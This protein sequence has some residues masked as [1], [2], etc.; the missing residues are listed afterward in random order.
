[1]TMFEPDIPPATSEHFLTRKERREQLRAE[2]IG[3]EAILGERPID[4]LH[5][6]VDGCTH[7]DY[8]QATIY[9]AGHITADSYRSVATAFL[10]SK[11][12]EVLDPF[13]P[14]RDFRGREDTV[15]C[16]EL[17]EGDIEDITHSHAVL[18]DL[19]IPSAGTSMECWFAHSIGRPVY[20]FVEKGGRVSPWI[21]Y[22]AKDNKT[23][24]SLADALTTLIADLG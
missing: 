10:E 19:T 2:R 4:T 15:T 8:T 3:L 16:Q 21:N 22:V 13:R 12:F 20:P 6:P 7:G 23:F 14:E 17:V 5:C 11:G 9:L 24:G 1:M 18:A